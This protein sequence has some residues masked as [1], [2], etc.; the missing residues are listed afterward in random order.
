MGGRPL[1]PVPSCKHRQGPDQTV[2]AG[3]ARGARPAT[4]SAPLRHAAVGAAPP[5]VSPGHCEA[6]RA[7]RSAS[8]GH[9]RRS[10][11]HFTSGACAGTAGSAPVWGPHVPNPLCLRLSP[12]AQGQWVLHSDPYQ[13]HLCSCT[14]CFVSAS[15]CVCHLFSA[16]DAGGLFVADGS[17]P[18]HKASLRK[19]AGAQCRHRALTFHL[20]RLT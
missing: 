14:G 13:R 8:A 9:I 4:R 15:V 17:R 10:P 16:S 18:P 11:S 3:A 2:L 1:T 19:P 6:A 20:A 5:P 7:G 12:V